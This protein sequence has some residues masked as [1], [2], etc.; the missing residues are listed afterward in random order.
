[1]CP[2]SVQLL[3]SAHRHMSAPRS[4]A[5]SI[6]AVIA[7]PYPLFGGPVGLTGNDL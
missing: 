5:Q 7:I 1:M 4:L 2:L 3:R 6:E